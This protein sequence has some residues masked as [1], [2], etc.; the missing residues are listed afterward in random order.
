MSDTIDWNVKIGLAAAVGA[1]TGGTAVAA[2]DDGRYMIEEII[3]TANKQGNVSVQDLATSVQAIGEEELKRAQ[4]FSVED[5]SRFIPSMSYM[6]N[7]SGAGKVFFRGV[8]DAPDTFIAQSSAAVYLD[9]QPLTQSAQVDVRLIDIER[10]EAL[11]GPQGTLFGSS[12]QS[13]TLRIVTNK[14]TPDEFEAFI[15]VT[16][17]GSSEGDPSYDIS[18]MVNIPVNDNFAV[19]LVGFSAKQGGF[20]DN[21]LGQTAGSETS[22]PFPRTSINGVQLND[23][24]VGGVQV[25][26]SVVEDDWNEQTIDGGRIAAKWDVTDNLSMTAQIAFQDVDSDAESTYDATQGDLE[27]VQ[28]FPDVRKDEWTQYSF[29]VEADMGWANF[30]S[31]TAYFTR[32]SFYQ[33]DT[34]SYSAYFGGFC[35]YATASYNIYCFQPAGVNYTYNDPIGFLTNDQENTSFSQEF[36]LS[37]QGDR[38]DWVA[39]VFYERRHEEWDFD[40]YTTND[41]GYRNS[42]GFANWGADYWNV[43]PLTPS[44]VWWFS[45]DDTDWDTL[46]AFGEVTMHWTDKFSTTVGARWF[47]VDMDKKYY[48][49]LP[50]GRL[51]PTGI[52]KHGCLV[53]QGPCNAGDSTD[54]SDIGITSPT[55]N[56]DDLAIKVA[57]QYNLDDDKMIYGLY[58]EGFRAGGTNRNRGNPFFPVQFEPDFLDN[59][60]L[61]FRSMWADGTLMLNATYFSM[62]WD[63][64]QL[65]VVDPSNLGCGNDGAPPAPFCGQPWQKVITNVGS[66]RIDGFEVH[67]QW[68]ASERLEIGGNTT[69]LDAEVDEDVPELPD[70]SDGTGLPFAPDVKGSLYAQYTWPVSFAGANEAYVRFQTSYTDETVNQVQAIIGGNTPQ[71]TQDSYSMTDFKAGLVADGWELNL[72]VTNIDD[73]RGQVYQDNTDFEPYFGRNK[74][75]VVRPRAAGLRFIKYFN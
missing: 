74:V 4:L 63:D 46:A 2:E 34:T 69:W 32:D 67:F 7:S 68:L 40:T 8:A 5:Y 51:T 22:A 39:G 23:G 24:T 41:G 29:T 18:G 33:Q 47:D 27:T 25:F 66:A 19:R 20:I 42:Q 31:A 36:R 17:S 37:S 62:Q 28:F 21:V 71:M 54:T 38:V 58:S 61:G 26:D 3:V 48:V 43:N 15:D 53:S 11:S 35:Y 75:S 1:V 6:G 30:V 12:S 72:F 73:E 60:E 49:E 57:L 45:A 52:G 50:K 16:G 64:Y 10:V 13:G 70:V 9:E 65:E 14:P 56:E 59:Y 55:S 44:D